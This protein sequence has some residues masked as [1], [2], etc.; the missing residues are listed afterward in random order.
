[1]DDE[2]CKRCDGCGRIANTEDGEPWTAWTELPLRSSLSLCVGLVRPITC[3][4]CHG[5][6][7]EGDRDGK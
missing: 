4:D 3:P 2:K 5:S 7:R 1:M 6:G